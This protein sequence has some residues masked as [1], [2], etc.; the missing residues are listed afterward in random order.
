MVQT[1]LFRVGIETQTWRIAVWPR[2]AGESGA[3]WGSGI[4]M[5]TL[6]S[7]K[8]LGKGLQDGGDT[9]TYGQFILM[10]GKNHHNIVKSLSSD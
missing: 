2:W 10:G 1:N 5:C 7:V 3:D 4:D 8:Q 6:P 9:Y